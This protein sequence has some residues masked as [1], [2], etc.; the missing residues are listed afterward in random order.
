MCDYSLHNV[1][2]RP[3]R[4]GDRLVTTSFRNTC[5]RGFAALDEPGVAVCLLPGTELAFESDIDWDRPFAWFRRK[6]SVGK[7]ARFRQVALKDPHAHHDAIEFP[8]G[9]IVLLTVLSRGQKATVLQLPSGAQARH[10]PAE[11]GADR[12]VTAAPPPAIAAY[13]P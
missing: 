11:I 10:D 7:V 9:K 2:S 8:N 6:E 13:R 3:A 1:A 5:T 4:L 12:R